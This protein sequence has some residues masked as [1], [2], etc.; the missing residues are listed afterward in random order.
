MWQK[1]SNQWHAMWKKCL[2]PHDTKFIAKSMQSVLPTYMWSTIHSQEKKSKTTPWYKMKINRSRV[3]QSPLGKENIKI[4]EKNVSIGHC[5][6]AAGGTWKHAPI[7]S[8][9]Q[10]SCIY[11]CMPQIILTSKHPFSLLVISVLVC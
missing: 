6:S 8:M 5:P 9:P 4:K 10:V 3:H 7:I 11:F 1:C 2:H